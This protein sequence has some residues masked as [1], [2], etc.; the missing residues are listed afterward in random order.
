MD[1][2]PF[3][4][5]EEALDA[6]VVPAIPFSRHADRHARRRECL[7]VGEGCI[8]QDAELTKSSISAAAVLV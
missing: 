4:G 1:Q 3:Q 6:G 2:L 8:L 5:T 7:L